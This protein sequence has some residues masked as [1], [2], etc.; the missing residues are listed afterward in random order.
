MLAAIVGDP[1]SR[2]VLDAFFLGKALAET[3]NERLGN[4][5]GEVLSN[6]SSLQAEQREQA[7][8]FQE[9]VK[10][11]ARA[12]LTKASKDAAL[13]DHIPVQQVLV[14]LRT[15]VRFGVAIIHALHVRCLEDDFCIDCGQRGQ[16]K[17][18]MAFMTVAIIL[19]PATFVLLVLP[20]MF[21]N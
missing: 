20:E 19:S 18:K 15:W 14:E 2:A 9:E 7:R 4:A 21:N 13:N 16:L 17:R 1:T 8:Q 10:E 6:I 5:V 3:I 12:A 11:R